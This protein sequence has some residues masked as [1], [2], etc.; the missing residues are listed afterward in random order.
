[1]PEF[2]FTSIVGALE[3]I[4]GV[5]NEGGNPTGY[6]DISYTLGGHKSIV[7]WLD[8]HGYMITAEKG[9]GLIIDGIVPGPDWMVPTLHPGATEADAYSFCGQCHTT[10]W[11]DYTS[12]VGDD[13]N[14]E[15]QLPGILGTFDTS[16]VQCEACHGAGA[17][18]ANNPSTDNITKRASQRTTA[19]LTAADMAYGKPKA[20]TECHTF[21]A[22]GA[23][24][25]PSFKS[26]FNNEFGGERPG[27]RIPVDADPNSEGSGGSTAADALLGYD[28]DTGVAMGAKR[29]FHCATCH[30]PH[31]SAHYRDQD[32]HQS[33]VKP[34]ANC[35]TDVGFSGAPVHEFIA[36]CQD[37][38]MPNS[39]HLFKIDLS[40]TS[41]N[42]HH[43]SDDGRYRQPWLRSE[44]SCGGCHKDDYEERA[45][46]INHIHK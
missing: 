15:K 21:I 7:Y 42:A 3:M 16:G 18:H 6:Q 20:C 40:A 27:A 24:L 10:G 9:A 43:Y 34:C 29:S 22:G 13:R 25:Y 32:G 35:H 28:P 19:D 26:G 12:V 31:K 46:R 1:M 37:C 41:D 39:M 14:P 36:Q 4:E 8:K 23:S 30:D 45:Q 2:P 44:E 38:H 11:K 17:N 5:I 33:A